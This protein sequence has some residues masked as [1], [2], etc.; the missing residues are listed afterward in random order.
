MEL[1]EALII[2]TKQ[3]MKEKKLSKYSLAMKSGIPKSTVYNMLAQKNKT[4]KLDKTL[5][6]C[7]GLDTTLAKFFSSDLFLFENLDDN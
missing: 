3:L 2:R 5:N 6:I 1:S 4:F 7:R